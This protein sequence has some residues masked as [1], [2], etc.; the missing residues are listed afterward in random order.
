MPWQT[1]TLEQ[2]R[3]LNRD[4]VQSEL[5]SGPLI[6]NS[7]IRVMAD[8]NAGLAYLTLL[9]LNWLALQLMPDTAETEWL[10]RFA[11]I[12]VGGRKPATF[13]SGTVTVTGLP[14]LVLSNGSQMQGSG[15]SG[16]MIICQTTSDVTVGAGPTAVNIMA[17]TPGETGLQIGG[18]LS[19]NVGV[20]GIDGGVT[21]T[22]FTD[23]IPEETDD[24][25]RVRVLDRIREPPMGGDA[26]DYVQWAL[27]VPG[28]TRAWCA[29]NEMGVGTV[30]V[31]FMMD[32]LRATNT[33]STNGFPLPGDVA[34]VLAALQTK[35]PVAVK[36]FFVE[37]PIPEPIDFTVAGLNGGITATQGAIANSVTAML[38]A[39]AQPS[40]A[41]NGVYQ[42]AQEIYAAW[43]SEAILQ[44]E[45][46]NYFDLVMSDHP[47]PTNGSM[48]V[49]G[50][51]TYA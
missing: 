33:P 11:T 35:R 27:R 16:A 10:D 30:T 8:S 7:V 13:A 41:R 37:A 23:G 50:T 51:V 44:T 26:D 24:A 12:W 31:R 2:L 3:S 29:P 34:T 5:R 22:S 40:F 14:N 47:M 18:T 6:P 1:P 4:N 49:L 39:K 17:L 38:A 25:L 48:A 46:V 19:L 32:D 45:G 43:V 15:L 28:V 20:A 42:P 36:G 21:I 9:Y